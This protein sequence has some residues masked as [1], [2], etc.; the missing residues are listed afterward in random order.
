MYFLKGWSCSQ[1][2]VY[3]GE[4]QSTARTYLRRAR[5]STNLHILTQA[6]VSK[7]MFQ[8]RRL[9]YG[10]ILQKVLKNWIHYW[11]Y[12]LSNRRSSDEKTTRQEI[13][14][15][16]CLLKTKSVELTDTLTSPILTIQ[17][18]KAVGVE[19]VHEGRLKKI[20]SNKEVI[21]SAGAVGSPQILML[22]GIGPKNHLEELNVIKLF[23]NNTNLIFL[24]FL[25]NLTSRGFKKFQQKIKL[26]LVGIE[27]TTSRHWFE[28]WTVSSFTNF[29]SA[30]NIFQIPVVADLPVGE[31]LL[32]HLFT[33]IPF[34]VDGT[35]AITPAEITSW[36][37][38][39]QYD[40][41][42]KG[43]ICS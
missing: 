43:I 24:I 37:S 9:E 23:A 34:I 36:K 26:P 31:S 20:Y 1:K 30:V 3:N 33:D 4:R 15:N 7:V 10:L 32:D 16:C 21:L 17:G 22:S 25:Y 29:L 19:Y 12:V 39:L 28:V 14:N 38:S 11:T 27:L 18:K 5:Q 8:G 6:H 2:N 42:G 13:Q 35:M 41:F 40:F